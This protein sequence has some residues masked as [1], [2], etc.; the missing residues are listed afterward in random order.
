MPAKPKIFTEK[1]CRPLLREHS[2]THQKT[3]S[4]PKNESYPSDLGIGEQE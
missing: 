1:V 4:C 3:P 2:G